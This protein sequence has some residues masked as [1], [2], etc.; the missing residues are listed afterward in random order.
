ME[1]ILN[2]DQ[3]LYRRANVL[4]VWMVFQFES[5]VLLATC[6]RLHNSKVKGKVSSV[7]KL[8]AENHEDVWGSTS[9]APRI[10]NLCTRMVSFTP[11]P[12]HPPG[13]EPRVHVG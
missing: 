2:A 13:K 10:I 9:I 5:S 4:S 3:L 1:S 6:E 7:R 8:R 11:Q 12:L